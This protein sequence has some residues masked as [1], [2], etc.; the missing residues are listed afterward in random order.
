[1]QGMGH[2]AA[3]HHAN[4][5]CVTTHAVRGWG[6]ERRKPWGDRNGSGTTGREP[7]PALRHLGHPGS[8]LP[9]RPCQDPSPY[10]NG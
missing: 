2:V 7:R 3:H 4:V 8:S 6:H 10:P 1:M 9:A 5:I